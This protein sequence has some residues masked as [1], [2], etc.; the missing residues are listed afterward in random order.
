MIA[1]PGLR[2][3][4]FIDSQ[5]YP[6]AGLDYVPTRDEDTTTLKNMRTRISRPDFGPDRPVSLQKYDAIVS[7]DRVPGPML[8][9]L[10]RLRSAPGFVDFCAWQMINEEFIADGTTAQFFLRRRP[11]LNFYPITLPAGA[12]TN[13]ASE[14]EVA[15]SSATFTVAGVADQYGETAFTLDDMPSAGDRI[16]FL[17]V[18][19]HLM[20]VKADRPIFKDGHIQAHQI[21]LGEC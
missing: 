17:Y 16:H 20:Y 2:E 6:V 4:I 13:F 3:T 9:L 14:C 18:A 8:K 7:I 15:G 19:Q 11:A 1:A 12:S 21:T 10:A 5:P